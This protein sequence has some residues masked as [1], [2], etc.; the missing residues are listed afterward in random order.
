[1][2]DNVDQF[3]FVNPTTGALSVITNLRDD[4]TKRTEYIVRDFVLFFCAREI[5][6]QNLVV[7]KPLSHSN[8]C[9]WWDYWNTACLSGCSC[10]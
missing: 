10:R 7:L 4:D 5:F 1:M 6:R 8:V 2:P 3:F 9:H